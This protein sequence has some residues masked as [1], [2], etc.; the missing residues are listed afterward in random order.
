MSKLRARA[1]LFCFP[2]IVGWL[3]LAAQSSSYHL[4]LDDPTA[5]P[6]QVIFV[7]DSEKSVDA[8]AA[9]QQCPR[10][11]NGTR[12]ATYANHDIL[13][14]PFLTGVSSDKRCADGRLARGPVLKTGEC[15]ETALFVSP[16]KRDC[17]NEVT[18]II[19]S[20]GSFEGEDTAVR[21]LKA[22]RDGLAAGVQFWAAKIGQEKPD[23]STLLA[24]FNEVER[25]KAEVQKKQREY[26]YQPRLMLEKDES[27][28]PQALL[29]LYWS[30]RVQVDTNLE[31]RLNGFI[32]GSSGVKTASEALRKIADEIDQWKTKIDSNPAQQK[33]DTAFPQLTGSEDKR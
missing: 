15:W 30:G 13:G 20:D 6:Q 10:D 24:L 17:Q 22:H 12:S 29:W 26:H 1:V 33:L 31:L 4:E 8:F 19:F 25:S 23:G 5:G 9:S 11:P 16:Q 14:S 18:A 7:S 21:G 2:F 27:V 32:K 28:L 3:P